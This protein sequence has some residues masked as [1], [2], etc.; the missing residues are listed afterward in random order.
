MIQA[1][2]LIR[3]LAL[4]RVC[5]DG[6]EEQLEDEV[7]VFKVESGTA[8]ASR[9]SRDSY[10]RFVWR[11]LCCTLSFAPSDTFLSGLSLHLPGFAYLTV[12]PYSLPILSQLKRA[13]P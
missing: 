2:G 3:F 7:G 8:D 5:S 13:L 6:A 9:S 10:F 4:N 11:V 12:P 1:K